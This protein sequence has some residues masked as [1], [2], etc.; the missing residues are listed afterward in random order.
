MEAGQQGGDT[1]VCRL[2]LSVSFSPSCS[3]FWGV[4]ASEV[5]RAQ[6]EKSP[7]V[8]RLV[9]A[10]GLLPRLATPPGRGPTQP[11]GEGL[12]GHPSRPSRPSPLLLH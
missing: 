10:Q 5:D 12:G 2:K 6:L 7:A 9:R 11:A 3:G 1:S 4:I 8:S